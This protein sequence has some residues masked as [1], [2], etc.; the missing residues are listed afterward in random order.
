M[1]TVQRVIAASALGLPILL[2]APGMALAAD[3]GGG[4]PSS[5]KPHKPQK[6]SVSQ[7]QSN[8][9]DQSNENAQTIYQISVGGEG[10]QSAMNWNDQSN[11]NATSQEQENGEEEE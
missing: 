4:K 1:R 11:E 9:T 6:P 7:E 8:E 5:T 10:D 2:G 3:D